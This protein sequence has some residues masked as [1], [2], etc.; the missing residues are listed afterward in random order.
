M[1]A[2]AFVLSAEGK[3]ALRTRLQAESAEAAMDVDGIGMLRLSGENRALLDSVVVEQLRGTPMAPLTMDA[4]RLAV[5]FYEERFESIEDD[6]VVFR[7]RSVRGSGRGFRASTEVGS[8]RFEG[9]ADVTLDLG[10]GRLASIA[11]SGAP[12]LL[13]I[14]EIPRSEGDGRPLGARRLR[15]L[16]SGDVHLEL[17][18]PDA[19]P[20]GDLARGAPIGLD[21]KSIDVTLEFRRGEDRPAIVAARADGSVVMR[22]ESDV[23]RG[24]T[25]IFGFDD[26]GDPVSA[27]L[28][29]E[30]SLDYRL[31]G[32]GGEELRVEVLGA[33]PLTAVFFPGPGAAGSAGQVG[34]TFAGPG[35]VVA[36]DRGDEITFEESLVSA[37]LTD[38]STF[39]ATL[40]GDVRANGLL[41]DLRSEEIVASYAA[42]T[43]MVMRSSG[44]T[45]VSHRPTAGDETYRMRAAGGMLARLTESG[46]YVER[47]E[48][49][50]AEA[51]GD[52]P[53]RVEA[54]LVRDVDLATNTLSASENIL[55]R[56]SG[57]AFAPEGLVRGVDF[58]ELSGS[59]EDP[60]A[61]ICCPPS[62]RWRSRTGRSRV[63]TGW[64]RARSMAVTEETVFADGGVTAQFELPESVW[65]L[66][67]QSV[68]VRRE[69]TGTP[70]TEDDA[71]LDPVRARSAPRSSGSR[72]TSFA[73]LA[74]TPSTPPACSG[75]HAS[76]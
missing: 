56:T 72:R 20:E 30:P 46:W 68:L 10:D 42:D 18:E 51:L 67:A 2:E 25:A 39:D 21:A 55:Y 11:T 26:A 66:D 50:F 16:A 45:R 34:V 76:S 35:R 32:E 44:P 6:L 41:G 37:G 7:S 19:G 27:E 58:V 1:L 57:S 33:G 36:V 24:R 12:S 61:S 47:A 64:M 62:R 13:S 71:L 4:P 29:D 59:A 9:G 8:L 40:T 60:C 31:V 3:E 53:Y 73:K 48:T 23:Y 38:S 74:T 69:I 17:S 28:T 65:G 5:W 43:G 54:G 52:D 15:I 49:V 70:L 75:P 63:R 14:D 22:R